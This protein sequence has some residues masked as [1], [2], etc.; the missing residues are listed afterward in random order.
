MDNVKGG[1]TTTGFERKL[2]GH[3]TAYSHR[4]HQEVGVGVASGVEF[5]FQTKAKHYPQSKIFPA[6]KGRSI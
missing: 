1:K 6:V 2:F 5:Q 4:Q 3:C